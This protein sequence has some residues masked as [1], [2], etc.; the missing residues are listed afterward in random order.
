MD[1]KYEPV[2][3][4][5]RNLD[6]NISTS[7]LNASDQ[8]TQNMKKKTTIDMKKTPQSSKFSPNMMQRNQRENNYSMTMSGYEGDHASASPEIHPKFN[9]KQQFMN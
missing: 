2:L 3:N 1:I 6:R 8:M 9:D 5:I 7:R 4:S